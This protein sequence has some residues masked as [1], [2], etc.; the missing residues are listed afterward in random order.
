MKRKSL[1]LVTLNMLF[2]YLSF[3]Q[4]FQ[5]AYTASLPLRSHTVA[6]KESP[7][8]HYCLAVY[9]DSATYRKSTLFCNY[10]IAF[11]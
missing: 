8:K 1:L 3:A 10:F 5:W 11:A 7:N 6:I 2:V 9:T 4:D